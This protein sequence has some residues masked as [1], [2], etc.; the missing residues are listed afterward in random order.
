M[1]RMIYGELARVSLSVTQLFTGP[2]ISKQ[3]QVSSH[4]VAWPQGRADEEE[5]EERQ[6]QA[7]TQR[8]DRIK[9]SA[10][11][12]VL[13]GDGE[14]GQ[15]SSHREGFVRSDVIDSCCCSSFTKNAS[16]AQ[17]RLLLRRIQ[18]RTP[19]HFHPPGPSNKHTYCL[20]SEV[21]K[22]EKLG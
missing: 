1:L 15:E 5:E 10:L 6:G 12:L 13:P 7:D 19:L 11:L 18:N 14:R 22:K 4:W 17:T 9:E 20:S 16:S 8:H 2:C 3:G 21:E